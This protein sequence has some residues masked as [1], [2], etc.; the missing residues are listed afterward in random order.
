MFATRTRAEWEEVFAGG[1]ACAAPVQSLKEAAEHPHLA[2]RGTFVDVA[3]IR[4]PA[5]AP[6]FG[7]TPG[8]VQRPPARPGEHTREVLTGWGVRNA[9]ALIADG[10]AVQR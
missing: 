1:D 3:G 5:P 6:R 7:R 4:Q 8:A 10:A 2:G 9:D